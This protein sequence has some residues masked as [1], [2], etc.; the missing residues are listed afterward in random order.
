M[1]ILLLPS[2]LLLLSAAGPAAAPSPQNSDPVG[3]WYQPLWDFTYDNPTFDIMPIPDC[4]GDGKADILMKAAASSF[5]NTVLNGQTGEI[6]YQTEARYGAKISL[7]SGDFDGDG[8]AD[9]L[10]RD[11]HLDTGGLFENG[12][13]QLI[14][15][16]DGAILWQLDGQA[17]LEHLGLHSRTLDLDGDG[18]LDFLDFA[19]QK[20]LNAY[21]G[22]TGDPLWSTPVQSAQWYSKITDFSADGI[23]DLALVGGGLLTL[24]DG[25]HGTLLW[26]SPTDLGHNP[27]Y[28]QFLYADLTADG[29]LDLILIDSRLA[30]GLTRYAG[31]MQAFD[32]LTGASLWIVSGNQSDEMLGSNPI[33]ADWT[34]DGILDVM[35]IS[36]RA[37]SLVNGRDGTLVWR[38]IISLARFTD[39][40][41]ISTDL[42]QDGLPDLVFPVDNPE[43]SLLALDGST[44]S[45]MWEISSLTSF[46]PWRQ[47]AAVDL[48]DNGTLEIVASKPRADG[49]LLEAGVVLALNG[50]NGNELWRREGELES[51]RFGSHLFFEQ[52][53]QIPGTD[54]LIRGQ[55]DGPDPGIV[56]CSGLDGSDIW[57]LSLPIPRSGYVYWHSVDLN[58]D[59]ILE[60][61]ELGGIGNW[62]VG[63]SL[64]DPLLGRVIIRHEVEDILSHIQYLGSIE[65]VDG[66]GTQEM[67]F[68]ARDWAPSRR[69]QAFSGK[70]SSYRSG[71]DLSDTQISIS[72]GGTLEVAIDFHQVQMNRD[73]Q[74]LLSRNG[75][76]PS[77]M[78]G[79]LVPLGPDRWL[80]STYLGH[81][82]AQNFTA[83]T[84]QLNEMG[85]GLITFTVLPAQLNPAL[86]GMSI[87]LAVVTRRF[88]GTLEFS[89][90]VEPVL[91]TL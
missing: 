79:I 17:D 55:A 28:S 31:R 5:P 62:N 14:H 57:R 8:I 40:P 75:F 53:D 45:I 69:L 10:L 56:A 15:G 32:G 41:F 21:S 44:G 77:L 78:E 37:Q 30:A 49:A 7:H 25:A 20:H 33:L 72:A 68:A 83:P 73:Y 24:I 3:G 76:G 85:D 80:T 84:G 86:A 71:L 91:I 89:S 23:Q 46:R 63:V 22:K 47:Y 42:N 39:P 34:G 36:D 18:I 2:C 29:V 60:L 13:I 52:A 82:P 74:L 65:D 27:A 38:R 58:Q 6:W 9:L 35:S 50:S 67:L 64:I 4:T 43:L 16:G 59:G 26:G 12:R 1:G 70:Q 90:G 54:V 48:D 66:D 88:P 51:A 19:S 11:P 87:Y 61:L 81:Y